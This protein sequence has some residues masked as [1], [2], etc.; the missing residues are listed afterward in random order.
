MP[1]C[2][3][4]RL[5]SLLRFFLSLILEIGN[6]GLYSIFSPLIAEYFSRPCR[7]ECQPHRGHL[8]GAYLLSPQPRWAPFFWGLGLALYPET[9]RPRCPP[10]VAL[11]APRASDWKRSLCYTLFPSDP[12]QR[13]NSSRRFSRCSRPPSMPTESTA[14]SSFR[15]PLQHNPARDLGCSRVDSLVH[16]A[17]TGLLG[18]DLALKKSQFRL[19]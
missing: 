6:S 4:R 9:C 15:F 2:E 19:R 18:L 12:R 13:R 10:V 8:P 17:G 5:V 14:R 7:E 11:L 3:R 1:L 16:L